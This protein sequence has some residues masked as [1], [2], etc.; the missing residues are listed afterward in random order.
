MYARSIVKWM[1]ILLLIVVCFVLFFVFYV[2]FWPRFMQR[3]PIYLEVSVRR[4]YGVE[5]RVFNDWDREIRVVKVVIINSL[6]LV[7]DV[8]RWMNLPR[9]ILVGDSLTLFCS[10]AN[11]HSAGMVL[12]SG[13]QYIIQ[14]YVEGWDEPFEA[15]CIG[16]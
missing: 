1:F 15:V 6:G 10:E 3:D 4:G 11:L 12:R 2:H 9:S 8:S 13:E 5:V 14:V 16:R 7:R